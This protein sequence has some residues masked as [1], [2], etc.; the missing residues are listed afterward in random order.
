MGNGNQPLL[1]KPL[2]RGSGLSL[3][4]SAL[5][6]ITS[7]FSGGQ[8]DC[9]DPD[10]DQIEFLPTLAAYE[11]TGIQVAVCIVDGKGKYEIETLDAAEIELPDPGE[12][13]DT[14]LQIPINLAYFK[15]REKVSG[16]VVNK[17]PKGIELII[18]YTQ[19]ALDEIYAD[20]Y[21]T[22][23]AAFMEYQDGKRAGDWEELGGSFIK[24]FGPDFLPN[25][26]FASVLLIK[27]WRLPD[28]LIGGC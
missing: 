2:A 3:A 9:G 16:K 6:I 4:L 25:D 21:L 27:I 11:E 28:P 22:P 1:F 23:R 14:N 17:F 8:I 24:E 13:T 15:V 10:R 18:F 12:Q 5:V 26:D 20:G 19:D 7:L